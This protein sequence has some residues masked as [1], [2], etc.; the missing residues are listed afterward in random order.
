M[1]KASGFPHKS[2]RQKV[3]SLIKN[4]YFWSVMSIETR[5]N[6]SPKKEAQCTLWIAYSATASTA[7]KPSPPQGLNEIS[8]I[9][10]HLLHC[11]IVECLNVS[12]NPLVL[13][14]DKIY[15]HA[16]PAKATTSANS[17]QNREHIYT[18][19]NYS[20]HFLN[21]LNDPLINCWS[22]ICQRPVT[23]CTRLAANHCH[24]W[25]RKTSS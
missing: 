10:G 9:H 20:I 25:L 6:I 14:S 8:H 21:I 11:S 19:V 15:S 13:F 1:D 5:F 16:F 7:F 12:Q 18:Q 2:S 4:L 17:A 22:F 3:A 23:P 24:I